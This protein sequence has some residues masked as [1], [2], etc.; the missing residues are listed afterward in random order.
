VANLVD[1]RDEWRVGL[2]FERTFY[3]IKKDAYGDLVLAD[4]GIVAVIGLLILVVVGMVVGLI[5][6]SW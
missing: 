6:E 5:I 4:L 3:L 2:A 1:L